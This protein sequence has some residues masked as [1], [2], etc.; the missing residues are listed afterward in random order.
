MRINRELLL[1]QLQA[2]SP[3]LAKKEVVE[4][5]SSFIFRGGVI[6]TF[7]DEIA[8]TVDSP[9]EIEGAVPAKSFLELLRKLPEDEIDIDVV[10]GE[11]VVKGKK[12]RSGFRMEK[13]ILLPVEG[14]E[15]PKKWKPLPDD[16]LEALSI[17]W[18]SA[19]ADESQ[20]ILTCVHIQPGCIEACDNFQLIRYPIDTGMKESVLIRRESVRHISGLGMTE[21]AE[22]DNW[23]H[24]RDPSGLVLSC[25]RYMEE[26]L[27]MDG[28]F[29]GEGVTMVLPKGLAD[30]VEKAEI[31]SSEVVDGGVVVELREGRLKLGGRGPSGWYAE[32][33]KV[34]YDGDPIGFVIAPRLLKEIVSRTNECQV[35]EGRLY[36]DGGKFS[37]V[38]C[39]E[40]PKEK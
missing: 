8:C 38:F 35:A 19:G 33:K 36:V 25:R 28:V 17:V 32:V 40:V 23:L 11:L 9:L 2:V 18:P 29:K 13:E 15:V 3:G 24:F 5:S 20:F 39:T 30:A 16:F 1:K 21:F 4:Q 22:T 10:E 7:N 27:N 12:R 14:V 37:C 6:Q 31:F 34:S 26:Y